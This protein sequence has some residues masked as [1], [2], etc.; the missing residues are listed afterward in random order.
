[1]LTREQTISSRKPT[2]SDR[3]KT[4]GPPKSAGR[5]KTVALRIDPATQVLKATPAAIVEEKLTVSAKGEFSRTRT[6]AADE[7]RRFEA[8]LVAAE[9]EAK[10]ASAPRG[11]GETA[12]EHLTRMLDG[13]H[14]LY[15]LRWGNDGQR[16]VITT[17]LSASQDQIRAEDIEGARVGSD[18]EA[19]RRRIIATPSVE[20]G[21]IAGKL[22]MFASFVAD[23]FDE[24]FRSDLEKLHQDALGVMPMASSME[25]LIEQHLGR[26]REAFD[27]FNAD[28]TPTNALIGAC[29]GTD[30][31]FDALP[32]ELPDVIARIYAAAAGA[33]AINKR[34]GDLV[35]VVLLH[36]T[37]GRPGWRF[38]GD[39]RDALDAVNFLHNQMERA[40]ADLLG[41]IV[42][43]TDSPGL[44]A[45]WIASPEVPQ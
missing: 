43:H 36:G 29:A 17:I 7:W 27:T 14:R 34:P 33:I 18:H 30:V 11:D 23:N 25:A 44:N 28:A 41:L 9:A 22:G 45:R 5:Q 10:M 21:H 3:S 40:M 16:N 32:R 19:L 2:P 8:A 26:W 42:T 13:W 35:E 15:R 4:G 37:S 31:P 12:A 1:M 39:L 38:M 24:E 20:T 6:K